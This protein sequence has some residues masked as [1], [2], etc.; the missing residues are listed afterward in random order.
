MDLEAYRRLPIPEWLDLLCPRCRY[1]LR[2][3][4]G[5]RCPECGTSFNIDDLVT[6]ATPLRLPETT[7]ATRPVPEL[8]FACQSCDY[9]LRGLPG[10]RCPECGQPFD[11]ADFIPKGE[12]V[13]LG[14][15][16]TELEKRL[17]FD[18]L[19]ESGI[20][21]LWG[22][23][24]N[25]LEAV[26][27]PSSSIQGGRALQVRRDYYLD[28]LA[29]M[30]TLR[31]RSRG[32]WQCPRCGEKVPATFDICWNCQADPDETAMGPDA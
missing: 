4:P 18:R 11:L 14:S 21:C 6:S 32:L 13:E 20:P 31:E 19:R 9:P 24:V 3:L 7:P 23:S 5:H 1:P 25:P 30:H 22:D 29:L 26:T 28:A 8:G 16:G 2:G 10:E 15:I 17:I 27:G 12:W